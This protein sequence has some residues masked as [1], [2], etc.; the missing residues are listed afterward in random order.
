MLSLSTYAS[1]FTVNGANAVANLEKSEPPQ[2]RTRP[3]SSTAQ[4]VEGP[5]KMRIGRMPVPETALLVVPPVRLRTRVAECSPI[6]V[7]A[8]RMFSGQ[9]EPGSM[10]A[11]VEAF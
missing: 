5:E 7:G 6:R 2:Q 3:D 4:A 10:R 9:L 11:H 8:K 1:P